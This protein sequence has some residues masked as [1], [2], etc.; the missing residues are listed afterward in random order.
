MNGISGP[1]TAA[2]SSPVRELFAKIFAFV[3][4]SNTSNLNNES[5]ESLIENISKQ[6]P[7]SPFL[8]TQNANEY[9]FF[10]A[11]EGTFSVKTLEFVCYDPEHVFDIFDTKV[12]GPDV[13]I[14]SHPKFVKLL[15][16]GNLT[17]KLIQ[18]PPTFT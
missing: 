5:L 9:S 15:F 8:L 4:L 13:V 10:P 14:S 1:K 11:I 2:P 18:I 17:I 3:E 7:W 16:K 12:G 6:T